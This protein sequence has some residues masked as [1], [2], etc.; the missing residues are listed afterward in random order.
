MGF[1][2]VGYLLNV[3]ALIWIK[4]LRGCPRSVQIGVIASLLIPL[5][6][7]LTVLI[8][9]VWEVPSKQPFAL[10]DRAENA[11]RIDPAK[12]NHHAHL[13]DSSSNRKERRLQDEGD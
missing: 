10:R 12:F 8:F 1:V 3:V 4:R 7:F 13:T 5:F 6:G 11:R 9:F 2:A